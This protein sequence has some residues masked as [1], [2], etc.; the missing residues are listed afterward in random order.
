MS[1]KLDRWSEDLNSGLSNLTL[2]PLLNIQSFC[3]FGLK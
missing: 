3:G 1:L 2:V